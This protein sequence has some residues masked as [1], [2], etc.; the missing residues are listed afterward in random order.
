[1]TLGNSL[2]LAPFCKRFSKVKLNKIN[3]LQ[4]RVRF[5]HFHLPKEENKQIGPLAGEDRVND[6]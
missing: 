6:K 3:F 1:M 2:V 4:P 5:V